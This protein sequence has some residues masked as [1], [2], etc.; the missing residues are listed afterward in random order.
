MPALLSLSCTITAPT[1][2]LQLEQPGVYKLEKSTRDNRQVAHRK[3]EAAN[4]FVGGSFVV[5][6]VPENVTEN[7]S[8]YVYANTALLLKDRVKAL[9]DAFDQVSYTMTF[10]TEN[11]TETWRCSVADYM[12]QSGH[13]LQHNFMAL[14]KASVPRNPKVTYS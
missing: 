5:H 3:I 9:T 4:P 14:I 8:V 13:E 11:V 10:R 12:I 7:V 1:G 6:A 2:T